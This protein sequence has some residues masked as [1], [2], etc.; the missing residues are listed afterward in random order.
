MAAVLEP[1]FSAGPA[2]RASLADRAILRTLV[3]ASLFQAPQTLSE[4]HRGLLKDGEIV[5]DARNRAL[6]D[7]AESQVAYRRA[8]VQN[9]PP[10]FLVN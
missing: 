8:V 3:Y 4:L 10:V 9:V 6:H 5:T 7:V 1:R 2:E